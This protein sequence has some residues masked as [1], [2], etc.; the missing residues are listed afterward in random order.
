MKENRMSQ[1]GST[2]GDIHAAAMKKAAAQRITLELSID[3]ARTLCAVASTCAQMWEVVPRLHR[4]I[5][6]AEPAPEPAA[7]GPTKYRKASAGAG[8]GE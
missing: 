4:L 6:A 2:V 8:K 1:V 5:A 3:E 7:N